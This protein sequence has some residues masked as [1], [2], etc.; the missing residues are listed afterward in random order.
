MIGLFALTDPG[1]RLAGQVAS[2]LGSDAVLVEGPARSALT[3]TW[4]QLGAAVFFVG[5][6]A[7]IRLVA[8]LLESGRPNPAIVC[9]HGGYAVALN[10]GGNVLAAAIA[11]TV[12]VVAVPTSDYLGS[13][14]VDELVQSLETAVD[15]DLAEC[16]A[17]VLNGDPV[18]LLNPLGFALPDLPGNLQPDNYGTEWTVLIDDRLPLVRPRGKLLRLIPRTL[19]VGVGS[20]RG[21]TAEAVSEALGLLESEHDLDPRA[22]RS[23][24]TIEAKAGERGIE[25]GLEDWAFWHGEGDGCVPPLA[26]RT[27][28]E[29]ATVD[30]PH[31]A[32]SV[33]A[34][35]GTPSVAEAA[36]LLTARDF[37]SR[38]ELAAPKTGTA[39]V[40][41]AAARILPPE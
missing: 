8:P 27:A 4:P 36:A 5:V 28:A 9:V 6:G 39:T 15:G 29:L 37:G 18:R 17:A 40:T 26:F 14:P 13:S 1:R 35:V 3:R 41:V 32:D 23:F 2:G 34:E 16:S 20:I 25:A 24:A 7:G 11:E 12:D 30:V 19:V 31:P 22:V 21:V 10:A 38:V 33:A